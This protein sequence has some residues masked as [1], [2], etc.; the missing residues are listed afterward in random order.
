LDFDWEHIRI[1]CLSPSPAP[2]GKPPGALHFAVRAGRLLECVG[3][4]QEL[5]EIRLGV[6]EVQEFRVDRNAK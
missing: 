1:V 4:G 6:V 5:Q 2:A 3:V